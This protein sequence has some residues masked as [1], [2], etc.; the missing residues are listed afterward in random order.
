MQSETPFRTRRVT[1]HDRS[2]TASRLPTPSS[3]GNIAPVS[4]SQPHTE[5]LTALGEI[6]SFLEEQAASL[7]DGLDHAVEVMRENTEEVGVLRDAIDELREL[8]QWNLNNAC[9]DTPP[10]FQLTSMP[11]NPLASDWSA[12]LNRV[13]GDAIQADSHSELADETEQSTTES[14]RLQAENTGEQGRLF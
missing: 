6:R 11:L 10:P 7:Q 1:I 14:F 3:S 13:N 4:R 5:V 12:R 8:Y 9:H 2:R